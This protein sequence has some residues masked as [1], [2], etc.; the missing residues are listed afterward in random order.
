MHEN[1][2]HTQA[3]VW[4]AKLSSDLL[5]TQQQEEFASWL[6]Q[7]EENR[8]AW[9]ELNA[10]WEQLDSLS[11]EDI[12]FIDDFPETS[13]NTLEAMQKIDLQPIDSQVKKSA[14]LNR[15]QLSRSLLGVAASVLLMFSLFYTQ[16][17]QYFADYHTAPGE[18]RT[19]V[20]DDGS[21][22]I[23][24]SDTT[25]SLDYSAEQ[26]SI[27]L[28][29]GEAYFDVT[30]DRSRPFVV[31][32]SAGRVRAL[33]TEFDIKNR[34][35]KVAVTV[36]EHAVKV[37]LNNGKVMDSLPEGQQ[38]VFTASAFTQPSAVNLSRTQSWRKQRIVFQD[39]PLA[40]VMAELSHYRAGTIIIL[41]S[42]IKA[43]SVS[44]VFATDDTNIALKT[45][46]QSLPVTISKI[47]EK[48]VLITAK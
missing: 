15:H 46:E 5:T 40:E 17:P 42:E 32:T 33:G 10:F 38:L 4:Q 6:T 31:T 7:S 39:K 34:N 14:F 28:H 30:A 25:V 11:A 21:R 45:I 22:I 20:L 1:D 9:Q 48:L 36:F 16:M 8:R 35:A 3:A 19:L 26:R 44:G 23:M 12:S 2:A 27:V 13:S 47:T 24:N 37:S 29:Q 41:D 18:L 43:L